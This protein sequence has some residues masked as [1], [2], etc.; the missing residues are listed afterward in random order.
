[1]PTDQGV[2]DL[3][4]ESSKY[5]LDPREWVVATHAQRLKEKWDTEENIQAYLAWSRESERKQLR[6]LRET[7]EP[8]DLVRMVDDLSYNID[9][10]RNRL[11]ALMYHDYIPWIPLGKDDMMRVTVAGNRE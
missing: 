6:E 7:V 5:I 10:E 2:Q 3:F 8:T 4:N 9:D 1:M 11:V